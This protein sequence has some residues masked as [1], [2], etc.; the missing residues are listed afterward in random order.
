MRL[1][2]WK[3]TVISS[4]L[5]SSVAQAA[6]D[7]PLLGEVVVQDSPENVSS[8]SEA[9][10]T[11]SRL[12][13]SS[14]ETPATVQVVNGETI[15]QRGDTDIISAVT[16]VAGITS[17]ATAGSGGF[18]FS[19]RGFGSSSV[20]MLYDGV[21]SLI[22]TGSQTYPYDTWNVESIEALNGPASVLYGSGAIGA[23][24]NVV[25]RK[26]S[27]S[28]ENTIRVSGGS[29]NTYSAALD[30]TGPVTDNLLYRFDASY[31]DSDGY[32]D[33]GDNKVQA[34]SGAV[35]WSATNALN[36]TLSA[37]YGDRDQMVYQGM[38]L[39]NDKPDEDLREVNYTTRDAKIPFMDYRTALKV[40]WQAAENVN[41]RNISTYIRGER[42]W[43][44]S[45]R[46]V[47]NTDDSVTTSG[48]GTWD[49][50]Q[51]Q[52]GNYTDVVWDHTLFGLDNTLAVGFEYIN[53]SN[54]RYVDT[55][56]GTV[57]T[58]RYN[59]HPGVFP[60]GISS[61]NYQETLVDQYSVFAEDRLKLTQALSLVAGVR[62]DNSDVERKDLYTGTSVEEKFDPTSWRTGIVYELM[63]NLNVYGQYSV[64]FDPVS[65][66]CCVSAAQMQYALSEGKQTEVG[67]K[68]LA[69][70]GQ[71][72]WSLAAYEI[73]KD[74][75]L[76]PDPVNIGQ[77]LQVGSQSSRG[78]EATLS[79]LP[80]EQWLI[81]LNGT[82][83]E[84]Q[85]DDFYELVGSK[86]ESRNGNRPINTPDQS[87]NLWVTWDFMPQWSAQTAV[88]YVG[89]IYMTSDNT[90]SV[91]SFTIVDLGLHWDMTPEIALDLLGKNV[92]DKFYAYTTSNSSQWML[93]APSS[94]EL[95]LTATF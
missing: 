56:N 94:V 77:S 30:S 33:R 53:L 15:R 55:W 74:N 31:R 12:G 25:P 47:Y 51:D 22:N 35:D 34:V 10:S 16:R 67:V 23:A 32:I 38:P 19:A 86:K 14:L 84:A 4:V 50:H 81:Q 9:N 8:L 20:T 73:K 76:T 45:S 57:V 71:L 52:Y 37:D 82:V 7:L 1:F 6:N 72:E 36:I 85:Y 63:P 44:Y 2:N 43:K 40:D 58:D 68:Q 91:P 75:L 13:I 5:L 79:I 66:L 62:L 80:S 95:Q 64:A 92:F 21:K 59:T 65:N 17:L 83:L 46:F 28:A 89:D 49:Q 54:D 18:G 39:I 41:V 61:K 69:L 27:V 60:G 48:F 93:G 42:L 29:F 3:F 70:D 87:A 11:G 24:I 90:K 78:V 88:R 26:P